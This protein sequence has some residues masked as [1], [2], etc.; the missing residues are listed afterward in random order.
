MRRKLQ[1]A[2]LCIGILAGTLG[3]LHADFISPTYDTFGHL[4]TEFGGDGIPNNAVAITTFSNSSN[5]ITLGLTAHSRTHGGFFAPPVSN[6]GA[7][8]FFANAGDF[9]SQ[10]G[11]SSEAGRA[12]WN[13]AYYI[14]I[15]E[16]GT[17]GDYQFD[18]L[19]DFDPAANT[20]VS[21]HGI[22]HLMQLQWQSHPQTT[23]PFRPCWKILKT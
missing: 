3:Q 12:L 5:T 7:G 9:G 18:L 1:S 11:Q 22:I 6:N 20:T 4:G 13:F 15:T 14:N 16:G 2:F 23:L 19:Y 21:D 8:T 10:S 17:L